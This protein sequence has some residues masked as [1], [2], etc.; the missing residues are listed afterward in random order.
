[1]QIGDKVSKIKLTERGWKL[2]KEIAKAGVQVW[3]NDT[4]SM[5][6]RV[7]TESIYLMWERNMKGGK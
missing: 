5:I 4:Q 6:W 2:V 3:S 7:K 1:M